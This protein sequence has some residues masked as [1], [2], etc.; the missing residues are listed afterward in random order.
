MLN[1]INSPQECRDECKPLVFIAEDEPILR[2]LIVKLLPKEWI[3]E[4]FGT[5]ESLI[6][7]AKAK[8]PDLII[9]DFRLPGITGVEMMSQLRAANATMPVIFISGYAG[10]QD[11]IE[12]IKLG[13]YSFFDK[14]FD[15]KEFKTCAEDAIKHWSYIKTLQQQESL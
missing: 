15:Q 6:E 10:K 7:R 12:F 5:G 3:I 8:L 14:P 4:E 9:S 2:Q 11:I 1:K 13:A